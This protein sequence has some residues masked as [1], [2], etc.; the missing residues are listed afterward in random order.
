MEPVG[1]IY[2]SRGWRA[3]GIASLLPA[4]QSLAVQIG[5]AL[6][7]TKAHAQ[8]LAHQRV[9]QELALAWRIQE[10]FLP[11]DLPVVPGWQLVA[12]LEPARETSGDFYDVIRLPNGKLGILIA[13]VADKGMPAALYMAL[14]RTLIRTYAVEWWVQPELAISAA[15]GRILAD[16]QTSMFVTVFFGILDPTSGA[17]TYC[18][19]GHNPPYLLRAQDGHAA[20][21]LRRTGMAMGVTGDAHWEQETVQ[22]DH[23]DVLLLYTDGVTEAHNPQGDLFGEARLLQAVQVNLD[24]LAQGGPSAQRLNDALISEVRSFSGHA[25]R[26][27][28]LTLMIVRRGSQEGPAGARTG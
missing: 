13:D 26:S 28:D 3:D 23:G 16:T 10:S 8:A 14:S 27:D 25:G 2:L 1:G 15:N 20:Q 17:L 6:Y 7:S 5:S 19:A 18:N 21:A 24:R 9:E 12:T 4:V 22:M 11:A